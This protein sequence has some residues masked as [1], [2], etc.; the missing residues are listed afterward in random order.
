MKVAVSSEGPGLDAQ[1]DPRFGRAAG[2]VV[3]DTDSA[4]PE[5]VD[6][7][8]SQVMAQGAGIQTAERL[9]ALGVKAVLSGY[10]GPKA[11]AALQAAGMEVYQ[12]MDGRSVGE[13]VRIYTSGAASPAQA[14]NR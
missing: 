5:Y 12:D 10:V 8:E 11:F 3:V 4:Q 6:N 9:S 7:G 2:F 13:A 1:V 14:P